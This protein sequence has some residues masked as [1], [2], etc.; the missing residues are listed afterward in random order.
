[1]L[2]IKIIGGTI[3]DGTGTRGY[4]A[5]LGIQGDKIVAIGDLSEA[6]ARETIDAT[7]EIVAPGFIDMHT[8]SDISLTVDPKASSKVHDGVTTEVIGNCGIGVAPICE[9]RKSELL[10]YL[11]TRL[12]GTIPI[13]LS[14]P[15]NTMDQ[16]LSTFDKNPVA[17][18]VSPLLA[19]G[20][21][22][23]NEMG[24]DKSHPTAEQMARMKAEITKGFEAGCV[25]L[26]SGLVYMP[27]EFT[28]KDELAEL[29]TAVAPFGGFYVTHMRSE[30]DDLFAAL[31]EAIYI[32]QKGGVPL[33]VS[34][35]KL[36]GQKVGGQTDRLLGRIDRA[37]AEGLDVT[38]DTYPYACGT[39][40]LGACVS[41]WA[42]EGGADKM[43]ERIKDPANRARI[44]SEI[45]DNSIPGWQNFAY[46]CGHN[47]KVGWEN[48]TYANVITE[49]GQ[50]LLGKTVAQVAEEQHKDPFDVMFDTLIQ[51]NGRI[52][53]LNKMMQEEDVAVIIS[54]PDCMIG[55]D[56]QSLSTEGIMGHGKPH[57][58]AFGT[59]ARVLAHYSRDLGLFSVETAVRKMTS[60][61][62]ERLGMDRRGVLRVGNYADVT[63]F[64]YDTICDKATFA[65]PK[66]YSTGFSH[67]IVNG[68][69]AL[70]NGEETSVFSGRVLRGRV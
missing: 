30:S 34:H 56:G 51:E 40:S 32:A 28:T 26:S 25:G 20:A 7:G 42:F 47:G 67:V 43:L 27:G 49:A 24:F 50:E 65:D 23:I 68:K 46:S 17:V 70:K 29:C 39:T 14:L 13:Q 64:N 22:R 16:Y 12:V 33:H 3:V 11:G 53:I 35:L 15:W 8:H 21:I 55:S 66:Q 62:A 2:D 45:S 54:R 41:P 69:I 36:S 38:F 57:P 60:L 58:R 52:Q 4:R 9:E 48:I 37:R 44:R 31:D 6:E 18:N 63:I 1:M 5:D 10:T 19:Q 59:R 61:P